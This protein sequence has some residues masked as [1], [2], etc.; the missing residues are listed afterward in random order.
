[1]YADDIILICPSRM[2]VQ[3]MI[4]VFE[5]FA[6][7]NTIKLITNVDPNK[8]KT[9]CIHFSKHKLVLAKINLN[10]DRCLG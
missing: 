6:G 3:A 7:E 2:G 9:K 4:K 5:K 8:S 10:G 1:M